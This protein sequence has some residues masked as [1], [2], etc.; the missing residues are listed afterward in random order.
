MKEEMLGLVYA[1]GR[2]R[3]PDHSVDPDHSSDHSHD[4]RALVRVAVYG[5]RRIVLDHPARGTAGFD[6]QLHN[7]EAAP[8]STERVGAHNRVR[9][10]DVAV[11]VP[12]ILLHL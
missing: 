9:R 8:V 6:C 2:G 3:S 7:P 1:P 10:H 4:H 12:D 5:Q 11:L